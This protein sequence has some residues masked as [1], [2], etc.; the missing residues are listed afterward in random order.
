MAIPEWLASV[1]AAAALAV[2][3]WTA[4][5]LWSH[6]HRITVLETTL[7]LRLDAIDRKLDRMP[8]R[9]DD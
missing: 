7:Q 5:R 2:A 1:T 3:G 6:D 9:T 4:R 8:K